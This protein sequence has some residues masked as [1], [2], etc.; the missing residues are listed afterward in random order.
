MEEARFNPSVDSFDSD[1]ERSVANRLRNKG[2]QVRTQVGVS[3]FRIDLGI[4]NPDSPGAFLAGIECDGASYHS[5]PTAR[6]RDRVRQLILE[7]LNWKLLR[8]WSTDYFLDPNRVIDEI[9]IG[10]QKFLQ[11]Y[12]DKVAKQEQEKSYIKEIPEEE[13]PDEEEDDSDAAENDDTTQS[14]SQAKN[15]SQQPTTMREDVYYNGP[16][17]I[18][19]TECSERIIQERLTE[20][21]QVE[22][23]MFVDVAYRAYIRSAGISK[24]GSQIRRIL[25]RNLQIPISK[26]I[27]LANDEVKAPGFKGTVVRAPEVPEAILRE[28][29]PRVTTDIPPSEFKVLAQRLYGED[30]LLDTH[31][32]RELLAQ[33]GVSKVTS[34]AAQYLDMIFN[35]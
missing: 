4:V 7:G 16:K 31:H 29:G 19:P 18:N 6:D 12:Q 14:N 21:I 13:T 9:H 24:V 26:D 22:G 3:K 5:S 8:I 20:L 35:L 17:C 32:Y 33:Y 10:L 2:W 27:I 30:L 15:L 34:K 28:A 11:D 1:F 23:P 25:N